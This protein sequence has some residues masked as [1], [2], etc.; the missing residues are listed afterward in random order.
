MS[1]ILHLLVESEKIGLCCKILANLITDQ[2][3]SGFGE[4]GRKY[5]MLVLNT[6]PSYHQDPSTLGS[7]WI[8]LSLAY[9]HCYIPDI[10]FDPVAMRA[11]KVDF[12]ETR[13]DISKAEIFVANETLFLSAGHWDTETTIAI[14]VKIDSMELKTKNIKL[15]LP[16]RPEESQIESIFQEIAHLKNHILAEDSME[17]I[18][19]G[20]ECLDPLDLQKE[21]SIQILLESVIER[22]QVKYPMYMDILDPLIVAIYQLKYGFRLYRSQNMINFRAQKTKTVLLSNMISINQSFD[23][24]L[25]VG[26]ISMIGDID[27]SSAKKLRLKLNMQL[28]V[29]EKI[30]AYQ[31]GGFGG[32]L[33][34][35]NLVSDIFSS[36]LSLW[37]LSE[38][39]RREKEL[40]DQK[41]FKVQ[42][43]EFETEEE[44]DQKQINQIFPDFAEDFTDI[45]IP[46]QND[47]DN[48]AIPKPLLPSVT[49]D[50]FDEV[51]CTRVCELFAK[52]TTSFASS[53]SQ[54]RN[55][56]DSWGK[57]FC[58]S[59]D[60]AI[61]F[62][63][64]ENCIPNLDIDFLGRA[65]Y[66]FIAHRRKTSMEDP[67]LIAN[68]TLYDFYN[69]ENIYEVQIGRAHV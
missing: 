43:Y 51:T 14:Q 40:E 1:K 63:Q 25:T 17:G 64:T 36:I 6:F 47:F 41:T 50:V 54:K 9:L 15:K 7:L 58:H 67:T 38:A 23:V 46:P 55:F 18:C 20:L 61:L 57:A 45:I 66:L 60:A 8:H 19:L 16:I 34:P 30:L 22:I 37:E 53:I 42:S 59:F 27:N 44:F 39:Q 65:G 2:G 24:K 68:N 33:D 48:I 62:N 32:I 31:D 52:L 29:L 35:V 12:T 21:A 56:A 4:M 11:A 3:S 26:I 13:I 49:I 10:P 69:D 28:A 5:I